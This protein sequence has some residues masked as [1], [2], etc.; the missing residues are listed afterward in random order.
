MPDDRLNPPQRESNEDPGPSFPTASERQVFI[1]AGQRDTRAFGRNA[2][3]GV[4][5][6][7]VN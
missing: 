7:T 3:P 1:M 4:V 2:Q 6:R 5:V